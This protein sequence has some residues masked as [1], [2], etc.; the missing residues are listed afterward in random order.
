M[1]HP[2]HTKDTSQLKTYWNILRQH[3]KD[4]DIHIVLICIHCLTLY[5]LFFFFILIGNRYILFCMRKALKGYRTVQ[6]VKAPAWYTLAFKGCDLVT[7][8]F[9]LSL[10]YWAPGSLLTASWLIVVN[11]ELFCVCTMWNTHMS[12]SSYSKQYFY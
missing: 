5:S 2:L 1:D 7:R 4:A 6:V 10:D 9:S 11:H 8:C 12:H 3:F